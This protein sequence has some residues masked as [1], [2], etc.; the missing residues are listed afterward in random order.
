MSWVKVFGT[1]YSEGCVIVAGLSYGQPI[2]GKICK[3]L[4]AMGKVIFQY[5]TL[6]VLEFLEHLNAYEVRLCNDVHFIKQGDLQ[7]FHPLNIHCGFGNNA[8][9]S[10]VVLRYRVDCLQ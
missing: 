2:F 1:Y 6:L 10:F 9:R 5:K 4:L 7:D 3:V 8:N